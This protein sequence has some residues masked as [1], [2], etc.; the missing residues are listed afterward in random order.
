MIAAT[1]TEPKCI[2]DRRE[3]LEKQLEALSQ[4]VRHAEAAQSVFGDKHRIWTGD[5][6]QH[7]NVSLDLDDYHE[8]VP[9]LQELAKLGYRQEGRAFYETDAKNFRCYE[10]GGIEVWVYLTGRGCKRVQVGVKEVPVYEIQ[11]GEEATA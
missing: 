5:E 7:V 10:R 11:C 8:V 2:A 4:L 1:T 6:C 3:E 9:Y